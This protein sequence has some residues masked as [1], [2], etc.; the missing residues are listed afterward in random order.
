MI[1]LKEVAPLLNL[2]PQFT[3]PIG[4]HPFFQEGAGIAK[5]YLCGTVKALYNYHCK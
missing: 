2:H 5:V 1:P 3:L 4:I